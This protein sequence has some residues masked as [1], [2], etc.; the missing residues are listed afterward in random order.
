MRAQRWRWRAISAL[1]TTSLL[2]IGWPSLTAS[3]ADGPNLAAGRAATASSA[4]AEY[5][6]PNI[7]DGNASTYW[8]SA[9]GNLPQWVQTDLGSS[10]RVDEVTLK[11]PPSWESRTQT[12]SLQGSADGTS[13][14]TLKGSAAYSFSPGSANTVKVEFPATL[15]RFVRVNI[16]ANTGWQ[17]AQLSELEVRAAA[18]SSGN[19]A[20]GKTLKA[21]SGNGSYVAANANDGNRASYWASRENAFPQWIEADLGSSVRVDRVVLRLPDGWAARSQ[22]LKLQASTNGAEFTDLTASKEY[23]F[24]AAGGQSATISFDPTTTRYVRVLVTANSG[25][26]SAQLAELEVYGPATGDTQA[27]TAPA[28]LAFTE[29]ATGQIRLTWKAATDNT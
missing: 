28:D 16:T 9:G 25:S 13:F 3:A 8:E 26:P 21:S 22:T 23:R 10:A 7:T 17:A 18:E 6:A 1:V 11:L 5:P 12:L 24:D 19:L 20:A 2:M 4:H 27:P 15:T 14:A 29:P